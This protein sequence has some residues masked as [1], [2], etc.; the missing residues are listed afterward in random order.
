MLIPRR[1]RGSAVPFHPSQVPIARVFDLVDTA[2]AER[3]AAE[4]VGLGF[5]GRDDG[6]KVLMPKDK[7]L[8]KRI[9][10][11]VTTSVNYGLSRA[12]KDRNVRFWTYHEDEGHYAIVLVGAAAAERLGAA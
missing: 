9:G 10:H 7:R 12:G 6:F 8:A 1:R 3:A 11:A 2:G 5:D 4:M